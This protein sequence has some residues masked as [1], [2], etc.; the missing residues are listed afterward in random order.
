MTNYGPQTAEIV[1]LIDRIRTATPEQ[2][3]ALGKAYE[4][5]QHGEP[6]LAAWIAKQQDTERAAIWEEIRELMWDAGQKDRWSSAR[7]ALLALVVC[8]LIP[9]DQFYALYEPWA[10]VMDRQMD[11]RITSTTNL[12]AVKTAIEGGESIAR[13]VSKLQDAAID[14]L[15]EV[16]SLHEKVAVLEAD[17]A[18]FHECKESDGCYN[19]DD[20]VHVVDNDRFTYVRSGE[21]VRTVFHKEGE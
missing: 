12:E 4:S 3:S 9:V 13:L 1:R 2:I 18:K 7:D 15:T 20:S 16:E 14:L 19:D 6:W 17:L 11:E 10:S 5:A 8:D 21:K